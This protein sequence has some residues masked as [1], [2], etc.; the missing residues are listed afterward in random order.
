MYMYMYMD[1]LHGLASLCL[2][3]GAYIYLCISIQ[4]WTQL[5]YHTRLESSDSVDMFEPCQI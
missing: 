5:E 4:S 3:Q 1:I 2:S